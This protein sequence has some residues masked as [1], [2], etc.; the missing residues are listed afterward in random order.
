MR[1]SNYTPGS[2]QHLIQLFVSLI[3]SN[4]RESSSRSVHNEVFVRDCLEC[5]RRQRLH[6]LDVNRN[7]SCVI[8][9]IHCEEDGSNGLH[10]FYICFV[11]SVSMAYVR[12]WSISLGTPS[13]YHKT[14]RIV[15]QFIGNKI[16]YC[17]LVQYFPVMHK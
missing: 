15:L 1:E 14:H 13:N 12:S 17:E 7:P 11:A 6:V 3:N 8:E 2:L 10:A 5:L 9:V 16:S 4:R